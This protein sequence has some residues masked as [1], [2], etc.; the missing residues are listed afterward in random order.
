MSKQS[1]AKTAP[2]FDGIADDDAWQKGYL[3]PGPSKDEIDFW[4]SG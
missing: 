2:K 1:A 3:S 4:L